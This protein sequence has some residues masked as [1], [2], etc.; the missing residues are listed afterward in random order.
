MKKENNNNILVNSLF[1]VYITLKV[2]PGKLDLIAE[3][4]SNFVV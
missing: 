2:P 4:R 3:L 1:K